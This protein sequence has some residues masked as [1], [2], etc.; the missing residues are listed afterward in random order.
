MNKTDIENDYSVKKTGTNQKYTNF[1]FR[2]VST[3]YCYYN[4]FTN[5]N[6]NVIYQKRT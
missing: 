1:I 2:K 3:V 4:K 6:E 5:S